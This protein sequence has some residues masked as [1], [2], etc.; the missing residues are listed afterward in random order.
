MSQGKY[1]QTCQ[2]RH[3]ANTGSNL[4]GYFVL[5]SESVAKH[6]LIKKARLILK[7]YEIQEAMENFVFPD[8]IETKLMKMRKL[9]NI[10]YDP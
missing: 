9:M 4:L 5:Q 10:F 3:Q 7:E 6:C 1:S 8:E 2:Y